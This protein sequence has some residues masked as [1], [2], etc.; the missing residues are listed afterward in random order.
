MWLSHPYSQEILSRLVNKKVLDRMAYLL[1]GWLLF[2]S[3]NIAC[4]ERLPSVVVHEEP[5]TEVLRKEQ[6]ELVPKVM[7]LLFFL[8]LFE[9][10]PVAVFTLPVRH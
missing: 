6:K 7:G 2:P 1:S 9:D 5:R 4:V 3:L 10:Y 8:V